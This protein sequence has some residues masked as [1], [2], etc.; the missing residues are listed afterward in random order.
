[1]MDFLKA[2]FKKLNNP[3]P[4]FL[5]LFYILTLILI[6]ASL[7]LLFI[8]FEKAPLSVIAYA[9]FALSAICLT[10]AVYTVV[11]FSPDIK[12]TISS[13]MRQNQFLNKLIEEYSFRTLVFASL[14]FVINLAYV[15]FHVVISAISSSVWYAALAGY[16]I[17]LTVMRG[18]IVLY[19][20]KTNKGLDKDESLEVKKYKRCG[21]LLVLMP[22]C[23]SFAI[24]EM[25]ASD[26]G[27]HYQGLVIYAV[28]AYTFYKITMAII[29]AVKVRKNYG[30][31]IEAIRNIGLADALVSVLA[32][33]TAMFH[34]FGGEGI[35]SS[36][37]NALTG[38]AVCALTVAI[39]VL[40]LI[41]SV[42]YKKETKNETGNE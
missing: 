38:A 33:Q 1:M 15:A 24:A 42:K 18:G 32:L 4:L 36:V 9:V 35:N 23:L 6:A 3:K 25:V 30:I 21:I 26:R 14:S 31:T 29:N 2:L 12:A 11:K 19:H 17:L 8:G 5:C 20:R 10:Y 37:A 22:I 16:Y 39:G 41:K 27:Y 28:A 40:M 13:K 34:S 7:S